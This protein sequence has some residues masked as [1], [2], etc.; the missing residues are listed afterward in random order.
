MDGRYD[1]IEYD[2]DFNTYKAEQSAIKT[3][4]TK[5][6]NKDKKRKKVNKNSENVLHDKK[7]LLIMVQMIV[8]SF[9]ALAAYVLKLTD[10]ELYT[11]IRDEYYTNI[12][13]SL[14]STEEE[15][16]TLSERLNCA[17]DTEPT[18]TTVKYIEAADDV[19]S[20]VLQYLNLLHN[21][22]QYMADD[23]VQDAVP[24]SEIVDGSIKI[25]EYLLPPLEKGIFTSYFG[26][27]DDPSTGVWTVHKGIDIAADCG[28]NIY[29]VMAGTVITAEESDSFGNYV[30]ID[31]GNNIQTL[32][33]H[34]SKLY[35]NEG[36]TVKKGD[37]I[38]AVGSTGDSTGNHLHF[39]IHVD[40]VC[41]DPY[42][43]VKSFYSDSV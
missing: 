30:V 31:H 3:E 13:I 41:Y 16:G 4:V 21:S 37:V 26:G 2:F 12:N 34:C 11:K 28:D 35:V 33:A 32:Y 5:K 15:P 10:S 39:E 40:D 20:D 6:T 18:M 22:T 29:S 38:A 24:T 36:D 23:N 19:R 9:L 42:D 43:L 1:N 27:R 7:Y 17:T 14:I 8:C 25:S